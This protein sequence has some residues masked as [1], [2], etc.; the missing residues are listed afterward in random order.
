MVTNFG[1]PLK[2]RNTGSCAR[3]ANYLDKENIDKSLSERDYFFSTESNYIT[4]SEAIKMI[5][6]NSIN[7][8]AKKDQ[9]RFYS[10][11]LN[12]SREELKHIEEN[13]NKLKDY[14]REV[15]KSYAENFKKNLESKDIVWFAKVEKERHYTYQDKEVKNNNK[16]RGDKKEGEQTHIH[17]VVSRYTAKEKENDRTKSISPM[18]KHRETDKGVV[19]GG[20]ERTT[21]IETN[22]KTFDKMFSYERTLQERFEYNKATAEQKREMELSQQK[23]KE[24]E[25]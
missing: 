21:F 25:R 19:K 6:D 20:F 1:S 9:D 14:T 12:P 11:T 16:E 22:E 13:P 17:V 8:G 10:F 3:L 5:D 2:G 23:N 4:K 7:Q 15:M 18:T 24:I